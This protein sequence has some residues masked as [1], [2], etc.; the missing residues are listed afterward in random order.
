[1]PGSSFGSNPGVFQQAARIFCWDVRLIN[2][3]KFD[4]YLDIGAV[5]ANERAATGCG[6]PALSSENPSKFCS[7]HA[8]LDRADD[9]VLD[10]LDL[11]ADFTLQT[12][13]FGF[14]HSG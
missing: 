14:D 4:I 11:T 2:G 6:N 8:W 12:T 5:L 13:Y 10:H 9:I 3:L 7:F 1:M